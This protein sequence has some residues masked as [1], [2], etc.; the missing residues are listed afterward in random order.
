MYKVRKSLKL[1]RPRERL[2][3][4]GAE[5]L[6]EQE[7]LAIILRT[8]TKELSATQLADQILKHFESLFALKKATVEELQKIKGIGPA[9]AIEIQA[10]VELGK[11]I[12]LSE[13]KKYGS[14][15]NSHSLGNLLVEELSDL[16]QEHLITLY[17]DTKNNIIRKKVIFIGTVNSSTANPREIL[18]Y[19]CKYMAT[20]III[21]HNH[22][23]GDSTPSSQDHA[24]TEK[25][26]QA[27]DLVGINLL[28]HIVVGST[29]Y[30]S[31]RE[32]KRLP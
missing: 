5:K 15:L 22:P 24:F 31:Y 12:Q 19:A 2:A 4:K 9:K 27:C 11:R 26:S 28:D 1:L 7:L 16:E 25:I 32:N 29:G 30:Y 13:V 23:S 17:L 3:A 14:I 10:M 8:G 20:S 21:S 6:S 18:Y